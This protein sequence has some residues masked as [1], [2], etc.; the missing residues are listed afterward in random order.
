MTI[1]TF[2]LLV[3]SYPTIIAKAMY[4]QYKQGKNMTYGLEL[5]GK[6]SF[7][8]KHTTEGISYWA[9]VFNGR[10]FDSSIK[11]YKWGDIIKIMY[12]GKPKEFVILS[13]DLP[14]YAVLVMT[15]NA[16][17]LFN[18]REAGENTRQDLRKMN[19]KDIIW[20]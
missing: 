2:N 11:Q 12:K 20:Q 19:I 14:H 18:E 16:F 7:S 3:S 10:Q 13:W 5:D 8:W 9:N 6:M 17:K 15:K 1:K 4:W